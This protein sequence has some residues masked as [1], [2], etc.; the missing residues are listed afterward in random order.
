M[1]EG[2]FKLLPGRDGLRFLGNLAGLFEECALSDKEVK[3][4][5]EN[6]DSNA[7]K[8]YVANILHQ[9]I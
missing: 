8:E 1:S 7:V 3:Q 4:G 2:V 9:Y 6:D 5:R